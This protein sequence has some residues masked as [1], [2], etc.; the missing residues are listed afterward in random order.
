V[1]NILHREFGFEWI[2]SDKIR[3]EMASIEPT[4]RVRWVFRKAYTP[5]IGQ[6]GSMRGCLIWRKKN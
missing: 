2:R 5:R 3:K 4:Q 1:A 6:I